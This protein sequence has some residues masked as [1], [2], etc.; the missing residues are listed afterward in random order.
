MSFGICS[1]LVFAAANIGGLAPEDR[2]EIVSTILGLNTDG[3]IHTLAT[4]PCVVE[5]NYVDGKVVLDAAIVERQG[6]KRTWRPFVVKGQDCGG[7]AVPVT[8]A[9][10]PRSS[11]TP[12]HYGQGKKGGE[13]NANKGTGNASGPIS[14]GGPPVDGVLKLPERGPDLIHVMQINLR[15]L[16]EA[17]FEFIARLRVYDPKDPEEKTGTIGI[18][19]GAGLEG[20]AEKKAGRWVLTGES[21]DRKGLDAR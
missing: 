4:R 21:P 16:T 6:R 13:R 20:I 19:C 8:L 7:Y 17:R 14:G 1:F 9:E 18:G 5:N 10:L 2:C 3:A 15:R 12:G 11:S